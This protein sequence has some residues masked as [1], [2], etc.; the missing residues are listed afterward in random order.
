MLSR[1]SFCTRMVIIEDDRSMHK[2]LLLRLSSSYAPFCGATVHG[3]MRMHPPS[4]HIF[5]FG[6]YSPYQIHRNPRLRWPPAP[7]RACMGRRLPWGLSS[8]GQ[9][10]LLVCT[11][12]GL[13]V[14]KGQLQRGICPARSGVGLVKGDPET[15]VYLMVLN[16][17]EN[18][19]L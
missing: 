1:C 15:E 13:R 7:S 19:I 4:S 18:G 9:A 10:M 14:A 3:V 2:R 8:R 12:A 5:P 11:P 16:S 6:P 17:I